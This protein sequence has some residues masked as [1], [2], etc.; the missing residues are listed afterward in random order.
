[1]G[2]LG[3]AARPRLSTMG[4][5]G[6]DGD[7]PR[8]DCVVVGSGFGG[9]VFAARIAA[10]LGPGR[11][12]VLERGAEIRPGEFPETLAQ[13]A[14]Q[15]RTSA[16]PLGIFDL[17]FQRDLDALVANL[18]G[19]GSELYAAVT[20][21]PLP[22]TFDIR[23]DPAD[24]A[25]PRAW[26]R[27]IDAQTL[28]PYANR[29]REMLEVERWIDAGPVGSA[30]VRFDPEVAG[31]WF[32]GCED[33]VD[34]HRGQPLRDHAGRE[35][36]RRPPLRRAAA[37]DLAAA[38][39]G[40]PAR[41]VP[42]AINLTRHH[43]ADNRFG[44][45]RSAC[46]GCGNC[47][48]GC[49]V[50][51]KNSLTANYLPAAV[52]AGAEIHTGAEVLYVR[53]SERAGYRWALLTRVRP[54]DG[55]VRVVVVHA[56]VV[57]LSAGVFGT[58]GILFESRRRGLP[59]PPLLGTRVS[60][61]GDAIALARHWSPAFGHGLPAGTLDEPGPTVTRMA[62]LRDRPGHRHL[63]QDAVA[64]AALAGLLARIVGGD[65]DE[66]LVILAMGYDLALGRLVPRDG[67]VEVRW[68]AAGRDP[69][70]L[71]ARATMA[72][73]AAAVGSPLVVNPRL[74]DTNGGTPV[75][76]HPLGG[77]PMGSGVE[78]GV[79]DDVGRVF[80]PAGGV[81]PGC[82]VADASVV[83]TPVGANPSLTIAALAERAAEVVLAEDLPRLLDGTVPHAMAGV[84]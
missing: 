63:V 46:T 60:G 21:E 18:L 68:P 25:S 80:D 57:V 52:A 26:P 35:V 12:A 15:I 47:V 72:A 34:R 70:Q 48:T 13:A 11:L 67:Q 19:G 33:G 44:M 36:R 45:P 61:N 28:R 71:S 30:A 64:P 38:A 79:V 62:D 69:A 78:D 75:T 73:M 54:P 17:R 22:Q 83:P 16:A 7:T 65:A 59:V 76:V 2:G 81:L 39:A 56:K 51:A 23:R 58:A 49:N 32:W 24:P 3:P 77:A 27:G 37:F 29:V 43:D 53:P 66:S 9:A 20:V 10:R 1:M 31:S 84:G 74:R 14:E 42:I 40:A 41:V 55:R 82:Y 5:L 6:A 4:A 50:G 8:Y